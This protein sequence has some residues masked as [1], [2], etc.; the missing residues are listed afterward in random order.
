MVKSSLP[1]MTF[2]KTVKSIKCCTNM[3]IVF[4]YSLTF[5]NLGC[6][7]QI[8]TL[9]THTTSE[10]S[11]WHSAMPT[12]DH[13]SWRAFEPAFNE[14][15][16]SYQ[17]AIICRR[18]KWIEM[19]FFLKNVFDV[20][21]FVT[22][23]LWRKDWWEKITPTNETTTWSFRNQIDLQT[24]HFESKRR[25]EEQ[26]RVEKMPRG[27][28]ALVAWEAADAL[29]QLLQGKARDLTGLPPEP[30]AHAL[31]G[32]LRRHP[33]DGRVQLRGCK[34]LHLL[35]RKFAELRATLQRDPSVYA[36]VRAA[37]EVA[38]LLEKCDFYRKGLCVW[39]QPPCLVWRGRVPLRGGKAGRANWGSRKVVI[40]YN[41]SHV[42][43]IWSWSIF[44]GDDEWPFCSFSFSGILMEKMFLKMGAYSISACSRTWPFISTNCESVEIL[45][46]VCYFY[47]HCVRVILFKPCSMSQ[48]FLR[49]VGCVQAISSLFSELKDGLERKQPLLLRWPSG[50]CFWFSI[51]A[52]VSR[53]R[54]CCESWAGDL[55]SCVKFKCR[56]GEK[57]EENATCVGTRNQVLWKDHCHLVD[58]VWPAAAQP[59]VLQMDWDGFKFPS[60]HSAQSEAEY[61]Q[62]DFFLRN[63]ATNKYG[64][65]DVI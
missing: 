38:P 15:I 49:R 65:N 5:G 55:A 39:L 43:L 33:K 48:V 63:E 10:W 35:C 4:C 8:A 6:C 37:A 7:G 17:T 22:L 42:K 23:R 56:E 32:A 9:V 45:F 16:N 50:Q 51:T 1:G 27:P 41:G 26:K 54:S 19:F 25:R 21:G 57:H 61:T 64:I 2:S 40:F 28:D 58:L 53:N 24:T 60:D 18:R 52:I 44:P 36:T 13:S 14:H 31:L 59:C 34:A 30:T 11:A 12:F 3:K 62:N 47:L 20:F 29:R 46:V